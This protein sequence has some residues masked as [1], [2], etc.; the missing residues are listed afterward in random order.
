[1]KSNF[2]LKVILSVLFLSCFS[3]LSAQTDKKSSHEAEL[4]LVV[5]DIRNLILKEDIDH[6]AKYIGP[7]G[8]F[9]TD[10]QFSHADVI[11]ALKDKS[12]PLYLSLFN[13]KLLKEKCGEA[14][15]DEYPA[16]SDKEFFKTAKDLK[17]EVS[18][19]KPGWV[20]VKISSSVSN[21][22]PRDWTF[23]RVK[24]KW[25]ITEGILMRCSCG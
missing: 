9:C 14:Y 16:I 8:L 21:Q 17:V 4:K 2:I 22:Y 19:L 13:S 23:H 10:D 12:S 24:G 25:K 11:A 20:E 1:M 15:S 7:D 18:D 6:F 5:S 3:Q